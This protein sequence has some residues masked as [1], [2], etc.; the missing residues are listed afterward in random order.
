MGMPITVEIVGLGQ[1]EH[2]EAVF[3]YFEK[4]DRTFSTYKSDSEISRLNQG[5]LTRR[6]A[7]DEVRTVLE[8]AEQTKSATSGYFDI[9]RPDG[10]LDP[11]G[12]VKGWAINNAA[13]L[14]RERGITNFCIDAGGDMQVAGANELGEPWRIG[15]RNPFNREENIKIVALTEHGIATSGTAVRGQHIYNPHVPGATLADIASVTV[16]GP[17]VYEADRFATAAFAMG[18]EAASFIASL[19]GFEAYVVTMK[20]TAVLTPGFGAFVIDA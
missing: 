9:V 7:S 15:I 2:I 11:S 19:D 5:L 12:L 20:G 14:L 6:R 8:L 13:S 10:E 17:D 4:V 16:I 18:K 3:E 1:D